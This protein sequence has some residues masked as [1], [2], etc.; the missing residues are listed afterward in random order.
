MKRIALYTVDLCTGREYLMPWRTILEVAR[1]IN[2]ESNNVVIINACY[3]EHERIDYQW[4]GI[5][6]KSIEPGYKKLSKFIKEKSINILFMEIK[7]RDGLKNWKEIYS[8]DCK[9]IA[10]FSGGVYNFHNILKLLFISNF[11]LSKPYFLENFTPKYLLKKKL[12]KSNFSSIIGLTKYTSQVAIK[13]GI[14]NVTTIYPGKDEFEY[15]KSDKNIISEYN[16]Y[17][18]KFLLFTGAPIAY[19]GA[20]ELI[21]AIDSSKYNDIHLVM[22][23]RQD[24]GSQFK[25][26]IK[27]I[28]SIKNKDRITIIKKNLTREQLK[29]FFECA[30]YAI[31]PFIIIPSEI[32]LTYFEILSCGT[33]IISFENGGTTKYLSK[34][35]V[36]SKLCRKEFINTIEKAWNNESLRIIKSKESLKIMQNHLSW[37]EIANEWKKLI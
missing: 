28:N 27:T 25:D 23:M 7:W 21:K 22:L 3:N 34:G 18:K 14:Q 37:D 12:K 5:Q 29:A 13:S 30:Y 15:I 8:L 20:I 36:I 9:K 19:R 4:N 24:K 2:D 1:R 16:L 17:N 6:I 35:L 33:P 11:K 26:F 32:P 10:Y 31:L